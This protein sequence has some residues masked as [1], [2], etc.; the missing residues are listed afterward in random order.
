MLLSRKKVHR[1]GYGFQARENPVG[2]G[3]KGGEK[4]GEKKS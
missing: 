3:G 2:G 4:Q 1:Q